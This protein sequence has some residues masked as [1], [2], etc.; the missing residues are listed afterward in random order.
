MPSTSNG[1]TN[2]YFQQR[3]KSIPISNALL[4][5][6]VRADGSVFRVASSAVPNAGQRGAASNP[7]D[8]G[9]W[10]LRTRPPRRWA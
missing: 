4:N 9:T 1:L 2:V 5:V 10:P 7:Q 3:L 6:S 8:H